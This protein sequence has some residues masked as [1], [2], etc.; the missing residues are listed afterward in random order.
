MLRFAAARLCFE[1]FQQ[2][3][4]HFP[5]TLSWVRPPQHWPISGPSGM[6]ISLDA[7]AHQ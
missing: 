1:L 3:C 6:S 4:R 2:L 7:I 5:E